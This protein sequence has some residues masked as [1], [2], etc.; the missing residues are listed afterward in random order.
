MMMKISKIKWDP[1]I[2]PRA[3]WTT[4]TIDR[5]VDALESGAI[6]PPVTLEKGTD[7][8]IDGKHRLEAYKKAGRTEIPAEWKSPPE[9]MSIKYF[10]ATLSARHGDRLPNSDLK[11]L[12]KE[13][14][15]KDPRLNAVEWGRRLGLC[16]ATIYNWVSDILHRAKV[17]RETKAW[18]LEK[19]GWTQEE[20]GARLGVDQGLISKIMKNSN[21]GKIHKDLGP[22]WNAEGLADWAKRME[23]GLTEAW[24]AAIDGMDDK[25]QLDRLEIK[26]QPFDV[27]HFTGCHDLMG[28]DYPGRIPG[29]LVCHALYFLTKSGSLV[30]DPMAGGGTVL[31][32]CLLMGRK[33]RGYDIDKRH[34][35]VD[36]ENHDL[37]EGWPPLTGKAD[38]IFWDPP[39]FEKRDVD[40]AAG[41]ISN[42]PPTE[43]LKWLAIRFGEL[44]KKVKQGTRLAFLMSDW[45]SENS[46]KY[47]DSP[48]IYLWD[49]ARELQKAGWTLRRQIQVPLS[50]Q[51][52][53]PDI[54]N[55]FRESKRLARLARYLLFC[56]K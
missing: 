34:E 27:W 41:S 10:A 20:I 23:V 17:G 18:R 7:R 37:S 33:A 24:A 6:F 16:K 9:G 52:I 39:Y 56:E 32:A 47:S 36:I 51:Q 53:H 15:E 44:H 29:E 45:D 46:R 14:F 35:R 26:I 42:F 8:L 19:L 50:T 5:Y 1:S 55:K 54:V 25:E 48:G 30:L 43:Y 31:D 40:Y 49:Y 13:E 22:H 2:Y 4:E 11:T 3:K 21:F 12:A 38:L 28:E